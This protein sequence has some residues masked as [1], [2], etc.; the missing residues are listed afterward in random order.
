MV[1]WQ[2]FVGRAARLKSNKKN[3]IITNQRYDAANRVVYTARAAGATYEV[4]ASDLLPPEEK[5]L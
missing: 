2:P 5:R 1:E 3:V 4:Y